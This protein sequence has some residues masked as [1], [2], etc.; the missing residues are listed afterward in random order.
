MV[1]E[2]ARGRASDVEL[3]FC[4]CYL[5]LFSAFCAVDLDLDVVAEPRVTGIRAPRRAL[6]GTCR[7]GGAVEGR[8]FQLVHLDLVD[9]HG[10]VQQD[11]AT[12]AVR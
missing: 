9:V 12:W 10:D 1:I 2:A 11:R 7:G 5:L 3:L 6:R 4:C 8:L